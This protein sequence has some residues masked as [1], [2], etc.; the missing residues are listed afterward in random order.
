MICDSAADYNN[1][2]LCILG[3]FDTIGALQAPINHPHCSVVIRS[4]FERSEEGEHPFRLMLIDQDGKAFGPRID[5]KVKITVPP[6]RESV[7]ANLILNMNHLVLP[8]FGVYHFDFAVDG[9]LKAR[10]PLYIVQMQQ[11]NQP[12]EEAA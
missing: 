12:K 8:K 11:P 4:R 5:G 1:G 9:S 3:A 7:T 10:L 6:G 2:K